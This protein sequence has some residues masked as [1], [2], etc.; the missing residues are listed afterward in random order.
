MQYMMYWYLSLLYW[1]FILQII[2]D[3][4]EEKVDHEYLFYNLIT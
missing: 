2:K 3:Q 4:H 1:C